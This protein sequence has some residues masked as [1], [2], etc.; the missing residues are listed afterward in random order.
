VILQQNLRIGFKTGTQSRSP[1]GD[2]AKI[3]QNLETAKKNSS[4][5]V[6]ENGEPMV[7]YHGTRDKSGFTVFDKNKIGSGNDEGFQGRGFYFSGQKR[8]ADQYRG[9]DGSIYDTFLNIREP[10]HMSY[11]ES[12]KLA[13]ANSAEVSQEFTDEI[14][15]E[16]YD[17]VFFNANLRDEFVALNPNQIKSAFENNGN[18]DNTSDDTRFL[19]VGEQGAAALDKAEEATTRIDN[20]HVALEMEAA[21]KDERAIKFATGWERGADGKWRYEIPDIVIGHVPRNLTGEISGVRELKYVVA[22]EPEVLK[23]YPQLANMPVRFDPSLNARGRYDRWEKDIT[24]NPMYAPD[25]KAIGSVLAHEIQHA[26]QHIEGFARGANSSDDNYKFSAGEAEANNVQRR[27]GMTPEQRRASLAEET[28][29]VAREDQEF[30]YEAFENYLEY[31]KKNSTFVE[32]NSSHGKRAEAGMDNGRAVGSS[33]LRGLVGK[34]PQGGRIHQTITEASADN[35]RSSRTTTS[36]GRTAW[37]KERFL[38]QLEVAALSNG[39]WIDDIKSI[40]ERPV[41]KG[42]ENEV[43]MSKDKKHVIKV[44]NLSLLDENHDFDNFIDR[45]SSHNELFSNIQYEIIGFAENSMGEVSVVL[46]Q[47]FINAPHA[48]QQQIDNYLKAQGFRKAKIS[49]GET[50]WTNGTYELWDAEPRNVLADNNGTLYFID[51]VVNHVSAP[52]NTTEMEQA[53]EQFINM[54]R[55]VDLINNSLDRAV[56]EKKN[57]CGE[58]DIFHIGTVLNAAAEASELTT[59]FAVYMAYRTSGRDMTEATHAAKEATVNFNRSG[60]GRVR[61]MRFMCSFGQQS[62]A[63]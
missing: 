27:M 8:V 33:A 10:Y 54:E 13:E 28:E 57:L 49:D 50:G 41:S 59:R 24:I 36:Q 53:T 44:N 21:D 12:N 46:K 15:S 22:L 18:F 45:L 20:K 4:K 29:D 26:I 30:I 3:I 38:G 32:N 17:G 31:S 52:A 39:T 62:T 37:S 40:A 43:Y 25:Y 63:A 55:T 11:E 60:N 56:K 61:G 6:D 14:V 35:G 2:F 47:P 48:T 9:M 5:V 7:V 42:Q 19:F 23:A 51:T 58:F 16:G 1:I 34:Q